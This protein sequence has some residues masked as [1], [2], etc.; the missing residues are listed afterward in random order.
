MADGWLFGSSFW[1]ASFGF[2]FGGSFT[3]LY[4]CDFDWGRGGTPLRL[5]V[6]HLSQISFEKLISSTP[7]MIFGLILREI[8]RGK[9][10]SSCFNIPTRLGCDFMYSW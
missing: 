7:I 3:W 6:F 10:Y 1:I 9:N 8:N 5:T 4:S 2:W